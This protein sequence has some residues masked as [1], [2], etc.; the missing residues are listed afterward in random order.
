VVAITPKDP[1]W[2][3]GSERMEMKLWPK[4]NSADFVAQAGLLS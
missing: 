3:F 1:P 4:R 2:S